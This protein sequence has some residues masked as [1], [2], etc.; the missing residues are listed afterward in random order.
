[1]EDVL[2]QMHQMQDALAQMQLTVAQ[3]QDENQDLRRMRMVQRQMPRIT[4]AHTKDEDFLTW[5]RLFE[6]HAQFYGY[7]DLEQ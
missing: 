3:L 1:M 2:H 5:I 4:Y 7:N 6:G